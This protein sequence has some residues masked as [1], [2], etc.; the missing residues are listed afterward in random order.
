[1]KTNEGTGQL[2]KRLVRG[3]ELLPADQQ[4]A[5]TIEP[6]EEPLY[7]PAPGFLGWFQ[8]V[9]RFSL[10]WM[11]FERFLIPLMVV[12]VQTCMRFVAPKIEISIHR[13]VIIARIQTQVLRS[14]HGRFRSFISLGIQGSSNQLHIMTIGSLN[15]QRQRDA[16][17]ITQD[18]PFGALF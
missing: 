3:T 5:R 16:S 4:P 13:V 14:L 17:T 6:R 12:G 2:E 18:A 1:M 8:T 7:H 10:R 9:G 11:Q 15:H